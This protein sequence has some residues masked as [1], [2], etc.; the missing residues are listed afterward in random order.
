MTR[1]SRVV[2]IGAGPAGLLAARALADHADEVLV[3]DR[4]RLP[5]EPVP[6]DGVPQDRHWNCLDR[7]GLAA[8]EHL[9]PGFG[10]EAVASG[11][12]R[13][14]GGLVIRRPL[15][16]SLV[17][18]RVA[19]LSV[20]RV[21]SQTSVLDLLD[22]PGS[23]RVGGVVATGPGQDT[24]TD[25]SADL[26][27]DASGQHTRVPAW[28]A[29]RGI[30]VAESRVGV[31]ATFVSREFSRCASACE[32]IVARHLVPGAGGEG[33][34]RAAVVA[35]LGDRWLVTLAG[36]RGRRPPADVVGFTAYAGEV[37]PSVGEL[38]EGRPATGDAAVHRLPSIVTRRIVDP[39]TGSVSGLGGLVLV[40]DAA[41]NHDPL[42]EGGLAAAAC[43]SVALAW[44][45]ATT[46]LAGLGAAWRERE[47]S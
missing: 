36:S 20:V 16:E 19:A 6:R 1:C 10:A 39:G 23:H 44:L 42:V 13:E 21:L 33:W 18:R 32:P 14:L 25:L 37:C 9:L 7:T 35:S 43:S 27:I 8:I 28:L 41:R 47:R 30:E 17:R 38:L 15:L 3:L 46:D 5:Q 34:E 12:R 11:G 4:D 40:G 29:R 2:V 31:N 22:S 45:A 26:V 24:I